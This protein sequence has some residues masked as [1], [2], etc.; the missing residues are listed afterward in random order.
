MLQYFENGLQLLKF[1]HIEFGRSV[2]TWL[3]IKEA[4]DNGREL[5]DIYTSIIEPIE[6]KF[7]EELK[8]I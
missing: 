5:I 4:Y 1:K 3:T 7:M 2:P 6:K 8:S